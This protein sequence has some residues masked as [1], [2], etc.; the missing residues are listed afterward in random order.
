MA[1][2]EMTNP[3]IQTARRLYREALHESRQHAA[4]RLA[5]RWAPDAGV[6]ADA[7]A[8]ALAL[9]EQSPVRI[10][11]DS[12]R[13]RVFRATL[14]GRDALIKR[15][16]LPGIVDKL[17]YLFRPSRARRA[18][19]SAQAF[20]GLGI[21]TPD[22]LGFL[23]I[24]SGPIPV[25]SYSITAFMPDAVSAGPWMRSHLP[26][27][28]AG[29]KAAFGKDLLDALLDLYRK[30]VYHADTKTPNLLVLAPKDS[31]KRRFLWIDLECVCFGVRPTR[32]QIIRNLV[33]LNGSL[34][35][36]TTDEERMAFLRDF[37]RT[38][39][40]VLQPWV[41][42]KIRAWTHHRLLNE[43]RSRCGS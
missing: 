11:K 32:H 5:G 4:G 40:W 16:D 37:A 26:L 35:G 20:V 31:T 27:Q 38:Y 41:I 30:G 3:T 18:W 23:E 10:I 6:T 19:A 42:R 39:P 25:R 34:R 9:A 14:L 29:V 24:R 13:G 8:S 22:P 12:D 43:V 21:S 28:T 2:G 7:F 36:R 33:Q 17:K 15:Y 1:A